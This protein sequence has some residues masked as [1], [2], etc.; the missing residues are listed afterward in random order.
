MYFIISCI[1]IPNYC[2]LKCMIFSLTFLAME[3]DFSFFINN[4]FNCIHNINVV[5]FEKKN[6]R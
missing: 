3:L 2:I 5:Y 4:I 1:K 6:Q